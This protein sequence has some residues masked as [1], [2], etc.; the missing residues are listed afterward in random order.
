MQP[1]GRLNGCTVVHIPHS[2]EALRWTLR[3]NT[4]SS[5]QTQLLFSGDPGAAGMLVAYG[6]SAGGIGD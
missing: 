6:L 1:K 2:V 4:I 3:T 5:A